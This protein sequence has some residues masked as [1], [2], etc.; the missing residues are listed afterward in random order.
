MK[1]LHVTSDKHTVKVH[2]QLHKP[3]R[4]KNQEGAEQEIVTMFYKIGK[5]TMP[6]C[7]MTKLECTCLEANIKRYMERHEKKLEGVFFYAR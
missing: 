7:R 4:K 5:C 1:D 6:F 3:L 2:N